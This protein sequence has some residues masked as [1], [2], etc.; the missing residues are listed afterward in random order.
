[1]GK[2]PMLGLGGV[3]SSVLFLSSPDNFNLQ[4]ELR[5]TDLAASTTPP[6]S[7]LEKRAVRP[8]SKATES[9]TLRVGLRQD[10]KKLGKFLGK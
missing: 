3:L 1:M 8:H 4:P 2:L 6:G 10:C 7:F 9:E 5:I